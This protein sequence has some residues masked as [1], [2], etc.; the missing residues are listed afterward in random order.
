MNN[1]AGIRE[2]AMALVNKKRLSLKEAE[3]FVAT[4]F[5]TLNAGLNDDKLVKLKGLGTF[6]VMSVSARKSVDVNTGE[7]IIIDGRDKISFTPDSTMKDLVNKPFAQFDTVII[8]DG[9]DIKDLE[10]MDW[11]EEPSDLEH[12]AINDTLEEELPV[13][14]SELPPS[15]VE[16]VVNEAADVLANDL[17][18]TPDEPEVPHVKAPEKSHTL[19]LEQLSALNDNQQPTNIPSQQLEDADNELA[20]TAEQLRLLN[21]ENESEELFADST[22]NTDAEITEHQDETDADTMSDLVEED[23]EETDI[24]GSIVESNSEYEDETPKECEA[25]VTETFSMPNEEEMSCN[26]VDEELQ[27]ELTADTNNNLGITNV[28][29]DYTD[30]AEESVVAEFTNDNENPADE[31][32]Q[33][34]NEKQLNEIE[35]NDITASEVEI[36]PLPATEEDEEENEDED[37]NSFEDEE[38]E[39]EEEE[40]RKKRKRLIVACIVG[41]LVI[42]AGVAWY[43]MDQMQLKNNRISHLETLLNTSKSSNGNSQHALSSADSAREDSIN[44]LIDAQTKADLA[45]SEAR[46]AQSVAEKQA[47]ADDKKATTT[48]ADNKKSADKLTDKPAQKQEKGKESK[49]IDQDF[50]QYEKD[51]RVR[52]GAYRIVG[53]D[54]VVTVNKGQ[55]LYSLSKSMLGPGMECYIEAVNGNVKEL[56]A[57]QKIKIPKLEL[58]KR[59]Q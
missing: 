35:D 51:A 53:I 25:D 42:V 29:I 1:R 47:K 56:K 59:K 40:R 37:N 4:M 9:V 2:L 33:E 55:T 8:N 3:N 58:K 13:F 16:A 10:R 6:K 22:S 41:A 54:Y 46:I 49:A 30:E 24:H 27:E 38:D 57:G 32:S 26:A 45:A 43:L 28:D 36:M 34:E 44:K 48:T 17:V 7:P 23:A 31:P 15:K 50:K 14:A 18:G 19:T 39:W 20:L 12:T 52:T 11:L 5:D 21:D